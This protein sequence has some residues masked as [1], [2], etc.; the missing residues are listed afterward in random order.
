MGDSQVFF[1]IM[2][3]IEWNEINDGGII[4][5]LEQA[6]IHNHR[7]P[8]DNPFSLHCLRSIDQTISTRVVLPSLFVDG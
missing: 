8:H 2:Y 7:S 6:G 1:V 4:E 3:I 5:T